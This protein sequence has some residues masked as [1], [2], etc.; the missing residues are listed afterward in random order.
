MIHNIPEVKIGILG[1]S[2]SC[3]PTSLSERRRAALA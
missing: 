1:V 2:R 3:F